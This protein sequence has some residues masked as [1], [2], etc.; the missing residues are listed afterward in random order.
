MP[1]PDGTTLRD[2]IVAGGRLAERWI[3]GP[4]TQIA[5]KSLIGS[6]RSAAD[7][8]DLRGRSVLLETPDALSTA[9]ALIALDGVARRVVLLPPDFPVEHRAFI[10]DKAE[11]E[12]VVRVWTPAGPPPRAEQSTEWYTTEQVLEH[13]RKLE[14]Q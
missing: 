2:L 1:L 8:A 5:L 3:A 6:G 4:T 7:A 9:Q 11:I 14:K 13:L 12:A 10:F